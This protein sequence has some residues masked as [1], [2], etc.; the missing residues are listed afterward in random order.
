MIFSIWKELTFD[1]AH[2]L[3]MLPPAH[4]CHRLHGHTYTVRV[5]VAGDLD[6]TLA[7]VHDLGGLKVVMAAFVAQ[8]DHRTL[9]DIEGLEN[10]TAEVLAH[11]F[12][13][14]LDKALPPAVQLRSV[15]VRET[16][17]SG[18]RVTV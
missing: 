17:T 15:E 1:A 7:W 4:Q 8:L 12:A 13:V 6:P 18:A 9:N 3:P 14:R 11:W 5:E 16:P 2:S 10:P